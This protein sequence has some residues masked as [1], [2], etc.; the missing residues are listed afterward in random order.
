MKTSGEDLSS[1]YEK[2]AEI[3]VKFEFLK[4]EFLR[5]PFN[6]ITLFWEENKS[7]K[8]VRFS[9]FNVYKTVNK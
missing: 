4:S 2:W 6:G 1:F 9:S 3:V 7:K 8:I 5:S